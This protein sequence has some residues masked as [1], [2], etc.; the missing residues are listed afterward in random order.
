[1]EDSDEDIIRYLQANFS[2]PVGGFWPDHHFFAGGTGNLRHGE[3][4]VF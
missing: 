1:V 2:V 4:T 3:N